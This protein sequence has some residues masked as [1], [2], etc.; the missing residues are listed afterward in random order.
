MIEIY[1]IA[2]GTADCFII[3]C[4]NQSET[5]VILVDGGLRPDYENLKNKVRDV[6]ATYGALDLVVITHVDQDHIFGIKHLADEDFFNQNTIKEVWFNTPYKIIEASE[7][8]TT[9]ISYHQGDKLYQIL[10][11]KKIKRKDIE[12]NTDEITVQNIG[13]NKL[14]ILS[15]TK[16]LLDKNNKSWENKV[17]LSISNSDDRLLSDSQLD[18]IS[19]KPDNDP[20]NGSSIAFIL[21]DSD[22]NKVLMSG[23]AFPST[24]IENAKKYWPDGVDVNLIKASHHGSSR[25]ISIDFLEF[26]RS[27]N[28]LV[29]SG[30]GEKSRL[31]NKLVLKQISEKRPN[32]KINFPNKGWIFSQK[33]KNQLSSY[34]IDLIHLENRIIEI[35]TNES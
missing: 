12:F 3:T 9:K 6:I 25:N 34:N 28:F 13:K 27:D 20:K 2:S 4:K 14:Y 19:V 32:S 33:H 31:P 18:E 5:K 24:M 16:K 21:E 10:R 11:K 15:P 17:G 23:D 1:S 7:K 22:K 8:K 26:F 35:G 29:S 30:K